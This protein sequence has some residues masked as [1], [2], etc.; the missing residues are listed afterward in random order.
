[1]MILSMAFIAST[2]ES[3]AKTTN[4]KSVSV[5]SSLSDSK[6]IVYVA[7]GK[8]VKLSTTVT[9]T[10][11]KASNKKVTYRSLNSN[12]A[13]VSA[14]GVVK[15]KKK[16]ST[17]IIVTSKKNTSK[18]TSIKVKVTSSP[19]T[20]VALNYS[21]ASV[22]KGKTISLKA[23]VTGKSG[24]VKK[25]AWRS[26]DPSVATVDKKGKVTPL[27]AGTATI[28]AT[29]IDGSKKKATCNVTVTE[30][31]AGDP[32]K[33]IT[34]PTSSKPAITVS[35]SE[36]T[37]TEPET[38]VTEH[39]TGN[40]TEPATE[41]ESETT[42]EPV[43]EPASEVETD[44]EP[45]TETEDV[46][47]LL[48]VSVIDKYRMIFTLSKECPLDVSQVK[49]Q[50]KVLAK[51][52]YKREI[53]ISSL[54]TNDHISY[55]LTLQESV[56]ES[57]FV[58]L[59]I[60]SINGVKEVEAEYLRPTTNYE[61]DSVY[62]TKVGSSVYWS[63]D[64]GD[65][66]GYNEMTVE[67]LPEGLEAEKTTIG[68]RITG[69]PTE[70]GVTKAVIKAEDEAGDT[71]TRNLTIVVGDKETLYGAAADVYVMEASATA[72]NQFSAELKTVGGSGDYSYEI[73]SGGTDDLKLYYDELSGTYA[74]P[75]TYTVVIRATDDYD[76]TLTCDIPVVIHVAK[77]VTV[78]GKITDADGNSLTGGSVIFTNQDLG[79]RYQ[80]SAVTVTTAKNGTYEAVIYPG[81]YNVQASLTNASA[82]AS[83]GCFEVGQE[84]TET[85]E[86]YNFALSLYK[87]TITF[88]DSSVLDYM[89]WYIDGKKAGSGRNL[90]LK[91]GTYTI[92]SYEYGLDYDKEIN[93]EGSWFS[94]LTKTM[95]ATLYKLE[96]EVTVE[97]KAVK[98][99]AVQ[100]ETGV[101]DSI[102]VAYPA[103]G[104]TTQ[105]ILPDGNHNSMAIK[106]VYSSNGWY[107]IEDVQQ[108]FK[109]VIE[110]VGTYTLSS[111]YGYVDL[112]DEEGNKVL[113]EVSEDGLT[114]TYKD[115]AAGTYYV[116]TGDYSVLDYVVTLS[117]VK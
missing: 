115:L 59:S 4:V 16:G 102:K 11:D 48:S 89:E 68:L 49:V 35:E 91:P 71:Q 62:T 75:G 58:K 17:K 23:T 65:G 107:H 69:T 85:K 63:M 14:S 12:V 42:E 50:V 81:T 112:Y 64:F 32:G 10:P 9:V 25:V 80:Q 18:K 57:E 77:G 61:V 92:E 110:E 99:K 100:V 90:Y 101:G 43:T 34:D 94:G 20:K 52:M 6:K 79:C 83:A 22:E 56:N 117:Q 40:E 47:D 5:K 7:K 114:K 82:A 84:L 41:V 30:N 104:A 2:E 46:T 8:S 44:S 31:S 53:A 86:D 76:E 70:A 38:T 113:S 74:E 96:A 3:L 37:A 111:E 19:V 33:N 67:N 108:A 29:A 95:A 36:T 1:M 93:V 116:G 24:C 45:E 78:S 88:E 27:K 97:N 73:I 60:D 105:E 98:Q 55:L 21:L 39:G 103:A 109:T 72:S 106:E 28:T 15:G 54:T 66:L 13:T 87:V 26:S 51:G